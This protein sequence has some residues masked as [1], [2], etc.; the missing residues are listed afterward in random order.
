MDFYQTIERGKFK[1]YVGQKSVLLQIEHPMPLGNSYISFN[2]YASA[3]RLKNFKKF[4]RALVN[5]KEDQ[6]ACVND[7]YGLANRYH[8]RPTAG[9]KPEIVGT[10]AF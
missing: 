10:I 4:S 2:T 5:S 7:I 6:F 8:L 9:R 1:Y 3:N